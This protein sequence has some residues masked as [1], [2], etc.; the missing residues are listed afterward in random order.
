MKIKLKRR[1]ATFL[2]KK[3]VKIAS[4]VVLC[5]RAGDVIE[6]AVRRIFVDDGVVQRSTTVIST[7]DATTVNR[8]D[9][10][11]RDS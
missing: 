2:E 3:L 6:T 11:V 4:H 10:D 8:G 1:L 7:N 5:C 9:N